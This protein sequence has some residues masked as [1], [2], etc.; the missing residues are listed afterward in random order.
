MDAETA[1]PK[2]IPGS[3]PDLS[4]VRDESYVATRKRKQ[5]E[6]NCDHSAALLAFQ[7]K[8]TE[9]IASTLE[10]QNQSIIT[11]L[12][13]LR[14]D[15]N[16]FRRDL[17]TVNG[18][19]DK[20]SREHTSLQNDIVEL[21]STN[22]THH[23]KIKDISQDLVV[24]QTTV[25]NL[26]D[27]LCIKEQQGR[28]NN[29][30]ITGIPVTKGEN[31]TNIVHNIANT[32]NYPLTTTDIDY[33]HRV[34]RFNSSNTKTGSGESAVNITSIPNIIVKFT[35]RKCKNDMLAAVR[36][37]R[38]LTTVNAGLNGPAKPIFINEHL[39]PQ[40]K[41]LYK[42]ARLLAKENGYK[43]IWLSEC[44][45]LLRK[46]DTSKIL[47]VSNTTDLAKIK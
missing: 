44:K 5:P 15:V 32:I 11:T 2:V 21:K 6:C 39:I 19:I 37:R 9:M 46:N 40:N 25:K 35:Q 23:V 20:L 36:A 42:E 10:T 18:Q 17:E 28:I 45:I 33:I 3:R 47:C 38:G 14:Q 43:Y 31:L 7:N 13:A 27:Q 30:E 22:T 29:L 4:N 26:K 34:R 8:I 16:E 24:L 12:E 1:H 41:L